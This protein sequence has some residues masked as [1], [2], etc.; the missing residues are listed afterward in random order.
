LKV[1][2]FGSSEFSVPFL[3]AI[4]NSQHDITLVVTGMDKEK[5]RGKKVLPNPVKDAAGSLN[6][7]LLAVDN[8]NDSII[9]IIE[10]KE[11]DFFVLVS[12]GKILPEKLLN[13]AGG[14]TINLHPSILPKHRGPSPIINTLIEGDKKTGISIIKMT[15]EIDAGDIY[16]VSEF[17]VKEDDNK[18]SLEEKIICVGVPL[19]LSVLDLI[20]ADKITVFHQGKENTSYTRLFSKKDLKI[21]WNRAAVEINNRIRA[22]SSNPGCFTYWKERNIKILK[23]SV[24]K[25]ERIFQLLKDEYKN[26]TVI[27]ADKSGLFIKCGA[28]EKNNK[29]LDGEII[30][31][32]TLKPQGK[33]TM[34]FLDFINGYRIKPG[35]LFE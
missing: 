24:Y 28:K 18:D 21:D 32:E 14:N 35:D 30:K 29:F 23:A 27:C 16:I 10:K 8:L 19:L 25:N 22:F 12:F 1:I 15:E 5:G 26:G 13:T 9:E 20:E 6:L 3:K 2:F 17:A 31:I 4:H 34:S 33:N 7:P 11:F